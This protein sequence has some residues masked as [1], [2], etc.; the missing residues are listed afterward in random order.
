MCSDGSRASKEKYWPVTQAR[1]VQ[2]RRAIRNRRCAQD[3]SLGSWAQTVHS[4]FNM[5]SGMNYRRLIGCRICRKPIR[6][7]LDLG[8]QPLANALRDS[9][10]DPMPKYPLEFCVCDTCKLCQLSVAVDKEVLFGNYF[11]ESTKSKELSDHYYWI[12]EILSK[13]FEFDDK[14]AFVIEIGS[15][16]GDF[17]RSIEAREKLGVEPA[18]NIAKIA[19]ERGVQT[20]CDFF[21]RA[22]SCSILKQFGKADFVVARHCLAHV[23]DIHEIVAG[24][25]RILSRNGV[26]LIENAYVMDTFQAAQWDQIYHEHMSYLSLT[27]MTEL[28]AQHGLRVAHVGY[29][30]VHG[31]SILIFAT[32]KDSRW[33]ESTSVMSTLMQEEKYFKLNELEWFVKSSSRSILEIGSI[34]R[35]LSEMGKTVDTF[36]A[37]AKGNTM[38][39]ACG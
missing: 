33:S 4:N 20:I 13:R 32:P 7:L 21:S 34:V 15:N 6:L 23:D 27:P 30:S 5:R 10:T 38:I 8:E 24:V 12:R 11:Y 39:N 29:S 9:P 22:V 31:G 2:H 28:L 37:S 17:L 25:A 14:N 1:H 26:F 36:G 16:T 3:A 18:E 19:R 35:S